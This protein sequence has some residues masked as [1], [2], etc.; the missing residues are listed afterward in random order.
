MYDRQPKGGEVIKTALLTTIARRLQV[1]IPDL[2]EWCPLLSLQ[3]LLEIENDTFS[4]AEWNQALTYLSGKVCAFS[5]AIEAK[6]YTKVLIR[7]WWL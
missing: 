2:R 4:V 5:N 1:S 6:I 7:R 3:A